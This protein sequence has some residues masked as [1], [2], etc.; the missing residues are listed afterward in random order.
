[1]AAIQED[2]FRTPTKHIAVTHGNPSR[3]Q[4]LDILLTPKVYGI[5]TPKRRIAALTGGTP[6]KVRQIEVKSRSAG[7]NGT[8]TKKFDAGN[9]RSP[10]SSS[11]KQPEVNGTPDKNPEILNA[12][13]PKKTQDTEVTPVERANRASSLS[14]KHG[15]QPEVDRTPDENNAVTPSTRDSRISPSS[16]KQSEIDN[17][18]NGNRAKQL[19]NKSIE[20]KGSPNVGGVPEGILNENTSEVHDINTQVTL[21][22]KR[23][24]KAKKIFEIADESGSTFRHKIP[25]KRHVMYSKGTFLAIKTYDGKCTYSQLFLFKSKANNV[26]SGHQIVQQLWQVDA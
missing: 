9:G 26:L 11:P 15:K 3:F 5:R 23:T 18:T 10:T 13:P 7:V 16:P 22:A 17:A 4:H 6:P 21:T 24:R 20:R 14:P 1:M 8:P 12:T 25:I 2:I 19:W